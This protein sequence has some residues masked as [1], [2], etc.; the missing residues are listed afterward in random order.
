MQMSLVLVVLVSVVS[1]VGTSIPTFAGRLHL[2]D[3]SPSKKSNIVLQDREERSDFFQDKYPTV[4]E[5]K[6]EPFE[7]KSPVPKPNVG[8]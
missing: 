6:E 3:R 8:A 1:V 5:A 2:F 7:I 4:L